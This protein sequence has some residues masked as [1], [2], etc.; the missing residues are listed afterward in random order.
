M[1]AKKV[2][3][4]EA[5]LE[6][7][8][9]EVKGNFA[10]LGNKLDYEVEALRKRQKLEDKRYELLGIKCTKAF[11]LLVI[12]VPTADLSKVTI[13]LQAKALD[14]RF[15]TQQMVSELVEKL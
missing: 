14:P 10:A 6:K 11:P 7:Y 3:S 13:T 9:E 8:R 4:L 12:L 5:D 15:G 1:V 2:E